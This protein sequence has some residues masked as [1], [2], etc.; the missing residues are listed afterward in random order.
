MDRVNVSQCDHLWN[1]LRN[2][3]FREHIVIVIHLL[4]DASTAFLPLPVPLLPPGA[5]IDPDADFVY[6]R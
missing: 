6:G 1:F 5:D 3:D 4:H 2:I